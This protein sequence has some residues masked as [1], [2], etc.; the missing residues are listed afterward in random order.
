MFKHGC[1]Q[2]LNSKL[3]K[4]I[5]Y[6]DNMVAIAMDK[7]H[8]RLF[9]WYEMKVLNYFPSSMCC[10]RYPVKV[11]LKAHHMYIQFVQVLWSL[12]I[13]IILSIL[14]TFHVIWSSQWSMWKVLYLNRIGAGM[15]ESYAK[16][17]L[18]CLRLFFFPEVRS[19]LCMSFL[20]EHFISCVP[21]ALVDFICYTIG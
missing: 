18:V 7:G 10:P 1:I 4:N 14:L 19:Q 11:R 20:F 13:I 12:I 16:N 8:S 3:Y 17:W 9:G 5:I 21:L 15:K 2:I 6:L